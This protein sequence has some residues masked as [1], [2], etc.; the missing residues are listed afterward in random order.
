MKQTKEPAGID[1]LAA[2]LRPEFPM[3]SRTIEGH[4]LAFLD[5]ASTT[6]KPRAVIDAV[7]RYYEHHTAN[8]HRGVHQLGQEATTLYDAARLEAASLIGASPDEIVFV[9]GTTEAVNLLRH[10]LSLG[11]EDEVVFPASEHHA[12]WLPW[13]VNTKPVPMPIDPDGVPLWE[14]LESLLTSRTRLVSIGHVSN[15]TGAIAPVEE[16][17]RIA[18]ARGI[19]VLLDA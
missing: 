10:S 16:V 2:Q 14:T 12:N 9:R 19:P 18:H 15:V 7:V 17:V 8:V 13:R 6:P 11:P 4:P 3:L 1:S 5:S